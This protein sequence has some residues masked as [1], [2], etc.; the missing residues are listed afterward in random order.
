MARG[1]SILL[2]VIVLSATSCTSKPPVKSAPAACAIATD[3]VT[4]QRHLPT[5]HVSFCD[6]IPEA[7]GPDG[8]YLMALR[9][10]CSEELCGSTNMGWFVVRKAT[11]DVFEWDVAEDQ[12]GQPVGSP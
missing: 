2:A 7:D 12:L 3:Q 8:Y 10:H 4:A 6:H 1:L 9:A 5:S 11:G